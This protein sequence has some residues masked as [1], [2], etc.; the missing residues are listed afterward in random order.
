MVVGIN[1]M[2]PVIR[3]QTGMNGWI[4]QELIFTIPIMILVKEKGVHK[5]HRI[6][7]NSWT[8]IY[9]SVILS[10]IL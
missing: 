10:P 7:G 4:G 1:K 3:I 6:K 8:I 9:N 5:K 2:T